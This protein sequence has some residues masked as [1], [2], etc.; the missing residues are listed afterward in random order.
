MQ[1]EYKEQGNLGRVIEF[2]IS[3]EEIDG[4]CQKEFLDLSKKVRLP[5]FRVGK[6]PV[7]IIKNK[8]GISVRKDL[9]DQ[10]I[11]TLLQKEV[12]DRKLDMVDYPQISVDEKCQNGVN[13][14]ISFEIKPE[15]K[16]PDLGSLEV[17]KE[18][19]LVNDEAVDFK[20][21]ELCKSYGS[22]KNADDVYLSKNGDQL[23]IDFTIKTEGEVVVTN[24]N[25]KLV[26]G[27]GKL[28]K[29]FEDNLY[30]LSLNSCKEFSL[31]IPD[32]HAD[33]KIAGKFCHFEVKVKELSVFSVPELTDEWIKKQFNVDGVVAFREKFR[34]DLLNHANEQS[35]FKVNSKILEKI[36]ELVKIDELP[37]NFVSKYREMIKGNNKLSEQ[38]ALVRAEQE[39]K[40]KFIIQALANDGKI[41]VNDGDIKQEIVN[42]VNIYGGSDQNSAFSLE[43]LMNNKELVSRI[44]DKIFEQ[45]L[46]EYLQAKIK[47]ITKEVDLLT[48]EG[49]NVS[50]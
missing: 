33:K 42:L 16:L 35:K 13:V 14:K 9:L 8:F 7:S 19:V 28:W 39:I 22:W 3:N 32:T 49:K 20:L 50:E 26:L 2:N 10:K 30:D 47:F 46:F 45:R 29:E 37:T 12:E 25:V 15:I 4:E 18:V 43:K 31:N 36:E 17:E 6:I 11:R 1:V 24:D 40:R 27:D 38:E 5:G 34:Q 23:V 48:F 41:L 21:K 44:G